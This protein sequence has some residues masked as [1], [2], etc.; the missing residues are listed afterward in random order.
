MMYHQ[1]TMLKLLFY[2]PI[3]E[4]H[5]SWHDLCSISDS[6]FDALESNLLLVDPVVLSTLPALDLTLLEPES[7]L[8]LGILDGVG[9]VADVASDYLSKLAPEPYL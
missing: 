2:L 7:N 3:I 8:L 4:A 6:M 5:P 9:T 1:F